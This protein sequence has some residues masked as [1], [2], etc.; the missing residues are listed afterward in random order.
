M[1]PFP[2]MEKVQVSMNWNICECVL[3]NLKR[4]PL[5]IQSFL[6]RSL[7]LHV[8]CGKSI[9]QQKI[10]FPQLWQGKQREAGFSIFLKESLFIYSGWYLQVHLKFRSSVLLLNLLIGTRGSLTQMPSSQTP[11]CRNL[12]PALTKKKLS[13]RGRRH[14]E[15]N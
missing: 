8:Y 12:A 13:F 7:K 9:I 3:G 2:S 1:F 4:F 14:L 11:T 15:E 10:L 5:F 6:F